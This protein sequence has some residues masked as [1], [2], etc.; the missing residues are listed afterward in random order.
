MSLSGPQHAKKAEDLLWKAENAKNE[1]D[2]TNHYAGAQVHATLALL[3]AVVHG[4]GMTEKQANWWKQHG[5]R[6]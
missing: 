2:R 6:D 5:V 4:G 1:A 3:A